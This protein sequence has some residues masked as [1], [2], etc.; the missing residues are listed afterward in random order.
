MFKKLMPYLNIKPAEAGLV[1]RLFLAQFALGIATAFLYVSSITLF[2][3]SLKHEKALLYLPK[4]FI[5]AALLVLLFNQGYAYIEKKYAPIK[6]L[7]IVTLFS[8]VSVLVFSVGLR[9]SENHL[10]LILLA[11][12]NIVIY[13]LVSY[14]FWGLTAMLFNVRESRRI[15]SIVGAGDIPGKILGYLAAFILSHELHMDIANLLW[16]SIAAFA[17]SLVSIKTLHS[18]IQQVNPEVHS[19]HEHQHEKTLGTLNYI[20]ERLFENKL[21]FSI[22][23][24]AFLSFIVFSFVDI[25][26]LSEIKLKYGEEKDIA[27]VITAFLIAGRLLAILIKMLLSSQV[28]TRLGLTNALLITPLVL[29]AIDGIEAVSI[30]SPQAHLFV[31]GLMVLLLDILRAT[32]QD[33]VFLILF[34]PLRPHDRLRGHLIAK[35]YMFPLALLLVG[36][37]LLFF[38]SQFNEISIQLVSRI[39]LAI[40]ILWMASVYL[41]K[42]EYMQTLVKSIKKGYFTGH[43]LFLNDQ[44]VTQLL[45]NKTKS[46]RPL[47]VIHAMTLL[48]RS[49]YN[50][51]GRLWMEQLGHHDSYLVKEYV[52]EQAISNNLTAALPIIE[53]EIA[54][55]ESVPAFYKA[56]F[57]LSEKRPDAWAEQLARLQNGHKKAALL[58]LWLR[59]DKEVSTLVQQE[60]L[61]LAQ[62]SNIADSK[63]ANDIIAEAGE[64]AFAEPLRLLLHHPDAAVCHKA[65]EASGKA[66]Q[67]LLF[68]EVVQVAESQKAYYSFQQALQFYG[69]EVFEEAYLSPGLLSEKMQ[70]YVIKAAAKV[71]GPKS[72]TYLLSF[73]KSPYKKQDAVIKALWLR[74]A[75]LA[76]Y[77]TLLEEWIGRQLEHM[78]LKTDCLLSLYNHAEAKMLEQALVSELQQD[79]QVILKACALIYDRERINRFIEVFNMNHTAK[80][81]NAMELLELTIPKKYFTSINYFIDCTQDVK[82]KQVL[83]LKQ[84]LSVGAV[85]QHIIHSVHPQFNSWTQSVAFYL[86]PQL[87]HMPPWPA[88][89]EEDTEADALLQETRNYVFS[90]LK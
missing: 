74:K 57:Y 14:A 58:G 7:Q 78:R 1:K 85:V 4:P 82:T 18:K 86:L 10:L 81:A 60:V 70:Q 71:K 84:K 45:L 5:L 8:G 43:D 46:E 75:N 73:L 22:S 19:P 28:I 41:I 40:L 67:L 79:V 62:S 65:I 25:T 56:Y 80:V 15:F 88:L 72:E 24:L 26:F 30:T 17:G 6:V 34:Q 59:K 32:V 66:K 37:F 68:K 20:V 61:R 3:H 54:A 21:I 53:K 51:I 69:D 12:W 36:G 49:G 47:E 33:P 55:K 27:A 23:L 38:Q 2:I 83:P 39:I 87:D 89:P 50:H 31:F 76:G 42:K 63:L 9:L 13:M 52:L 16:I 64:G 48:Q 44:S 11:A 35:G 29:L 77:S 90:I